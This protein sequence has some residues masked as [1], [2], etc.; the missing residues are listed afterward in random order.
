MAMMT[1][2]LYAVMIAFSTQL[3]AEEPLAP[4]DEI[5]KDIER[6]ASGDAAAREEAKARLKALPGTQTAR[7][8]REAAKAEDQGLKANL[9]NC[10]RYVFEARLVKTFD[11]YK[12]ATSNIGLAFFGSSVTTFNPDGNGNFLHCL[13][14]GRVEKTSAFAQ[15]REGED[16]EM[17]RP[18]AMAGD[19]ILGAKGQD[20]VLR[21][22]SYD[23]IDIGE[24]AISIFGPLVGQEV[25]LVIFRQGRVVE[26]KGK[27][28]Q[29]SPEEMTEEAKVDITTIVDMLW[30]V[31][32]AAASGFSGDVLPYN[33]RKMN[34]F[35][36]EK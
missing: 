12:M 16:G 8:V 13:V 28:R 14:I 21:Q 5:S 26:A 29:L 18:I 34:S 9:E 22:L 25:T 24:A 20:G 33:G 1:K 17:M 35:S 27:L 31:F 30:S 4:K 15:V 32:K 23:P 6:L 3:L 10:A 7:L 36:V 11:V 19:I 2:I